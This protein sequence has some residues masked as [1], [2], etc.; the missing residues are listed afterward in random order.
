MHGKSTRLGEHDYTSS[1][2]RQLVLELPKLEHGKS[3][4]LVGKLGYLCTRLVR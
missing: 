2:N 1:E 3:D 4:R